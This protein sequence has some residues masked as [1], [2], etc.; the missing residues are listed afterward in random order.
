MILI[1]QYLYARGSPRDEGGELPFSDALEAFVDLGG[2][3][4][5]LDDI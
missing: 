2:I 5:A 1:L 4:L 3:D